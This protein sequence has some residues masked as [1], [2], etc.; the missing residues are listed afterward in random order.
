MKVEQ[1]VHEYPLTIEMT[2]PVRHAAQL[3]RSN[4]VGSL[5]VVTEGRPVGI[6]TDRDLVVRSMA[7]GDNPHIVPVAEKMTRE[8]VSCY[9]DE[10]LMTAA[11]LMISSHVGRLLILG[12]EEE[13]LGVLT[14][15]HMARD[16]RST[17]FASLAMKTIGGLA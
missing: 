13:G 14:L 5:I 17:H 10:S 4:G 2:M 15:G 9:G 6:I 7:D 8:V 12:K 3:M 11:K 1:F 16:E